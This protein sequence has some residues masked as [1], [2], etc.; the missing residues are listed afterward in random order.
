VNISTFSVLN[1]LSDDSLQTYGGGR[2]TGDSLETYE[3]KRS[4]GESLEICEGKWSI[5]ESVKTDE[6]GRSIRKVPRGSL[7]HVQSK[8][9]FKFEKNGTTN[10]RKNAIKR[11]RRS[12]EN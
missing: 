12:Y 9:T 1:P 11:V 10:S 8:N 6:G 7:I 5:G 4:T 2:S 3:D